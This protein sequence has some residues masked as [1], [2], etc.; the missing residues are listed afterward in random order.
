MENYF[1]LN[2]RKPGKG[3]EDGD[4]LSKKLRQNQK[5]YSS[6][7]AANIPSGS[8]ELLDYVNIMGSS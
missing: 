1:E 4:Y 6:G 2:S 3:I 8:I 7:L 5:N